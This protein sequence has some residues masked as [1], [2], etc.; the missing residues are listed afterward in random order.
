MHALGLSEP[1]PPP[2]T[3]VADNWMKALEDPK[4]WDQ[5]AFNELS[6]KGATKSGDKNLWVGYNGQLTLGILPASIF[7]SGH[8][9]FVQVGQRQQ[10]HVL[11]AG[12][13]EAG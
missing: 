3:R 11:C 8:M 4:M 2:M 9:F 5:T 6:R 13:T 12:R 7:C 1:T 10:P